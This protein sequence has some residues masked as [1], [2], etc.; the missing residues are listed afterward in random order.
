MIAAGEL[1]H[2]GWGTEFARQM[3]QPIRDRL[4][5]LLMGEHNDDKRQRDLAKRLTAMFGRRLGRANPDGEPAGAADSPFG[6]PRS[7]GSPQ[8]RREQERQGRHTRSLFGHRANPATT[9]QAGSLKR[10]AQRPSLPPDPIQTR[11]D[12][13]NT[14]FQG[15]E[16]ITATFNIA[17]NELVINAR[18]VVTR[19]LVEDAQELRA[20]ARAAE[21]KSLAETAIKEFYVDYIQA[22]RLYPASPATSGGRLGGPDP[23]RFFAEAVSDQA[24]TAV[25]VNVSVLER[26]VAN[27]MRGVPGMSA[28]ALRRPPVSAD[29][30]VGTT[31]ETHDD[32]MV[33]A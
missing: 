30:N 32:G 4:N 15:R 1:P 11:W 2:E 27:K 7:A 26:M 3:P 16:G 17:R 8:P 25:G 31:E 6:D 24:L 12:R 14:E 9:A 29:D 21:V 23:L 33:P 10:A 19:Q 28:R 5:E 22:A 20:E 18:H 13:D